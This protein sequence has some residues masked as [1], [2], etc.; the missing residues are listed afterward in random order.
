[1]LVATVIDDLFVSGIPLYEKALRTFAVY[2]AIVILLRALGKRELAQLN[3]LD[4]VVLLLLSNIVQNALIGNDNSLTGGLFGV[5]VLLAINQLLVALTWRF[6]WLERLL[7]GTDAV[8]IENGKF[9]KPALRHQ[10]MRPEEVETVVRR[11]GGSSIEEVQR[12][13]LKPGGTI[14]IVLKPQDV[15]ATRRDIGR[16]EQKLD[17]LLERAPT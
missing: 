1:V 15:N 7:V 10:F 2:L 8:L 17:Q 13:T 14:E 9:S 6:R 16:L 5:V 3:T 4:L 11:Q 12:A